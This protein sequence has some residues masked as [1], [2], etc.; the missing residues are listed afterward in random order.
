MRRSLTFSLRAVPL[1]FE[2][3]D[4]SLAWLAVC[5]DRIVGVL[6]THQQ[7]VS[8]LWVLRENRRRGVGTKLLA[9]GESE[10]SSR[11]YE[12]CRLRVVKSNRV[13]VEFYVG[14]GWKVV[15]EFPHEKYNHAMLELAK[16][17]QADPVTQ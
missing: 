5:D 7:W 12:S 17:N 11:G 3:D 2:D 6:M 16:S 14:Q 1:K 8:D 13:A 15:R 10:I 9:R 4:W